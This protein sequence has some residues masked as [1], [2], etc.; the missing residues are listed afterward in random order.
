MRK[1]V[2]DFNF[3]GITWVKFMEFKDFRDSLVHPRQVDDETQVDEYRKRVRNG[4]K[5]IIEIMDDISKGMFQ[6]PLRK[7]LLDLIPE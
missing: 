5:A 3:Q 6:R 4:L 7:Q 2:P 1:F